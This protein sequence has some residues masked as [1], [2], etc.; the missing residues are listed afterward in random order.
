MF[1]VN[2]SHLGVMTRFPGVNNLIEY[3]QQGYRLNLL[4]LCFLFLV[5]WDV[6]NIYWGEI[7][8]IDTVKKVVM[9]SK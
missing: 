5:I 3:W 2:N 8:E 9:V 1:D 7:I 4:L 6:I